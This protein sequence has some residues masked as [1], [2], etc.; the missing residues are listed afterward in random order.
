MWRLITVCVWFES[1]DPLMSLFQAFYVFL[2]LYLFLKCVED[3]FMLLVWLYYLKMILFQSACIVRDNAV[4]VDKTSQ[5]WSN[6]WH[7]V[8]S[9]NKY[10]LKSTSLFSFVNLRKHISMDFCRIP[11]LNK[12]EASKPL[13]LIWRFY[14]KRTPLLAPVNES[15]CETSMTKNY[16]KT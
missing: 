13:Y 15:I 2:L 3:H 9:P 6:P 11:K 5:L 7:A 1:P 16:N 8:F 10:L 14:P 12:K 4:N